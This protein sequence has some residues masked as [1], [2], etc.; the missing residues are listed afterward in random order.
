MHLHEMKRREIVALL[1][2]AAVWP[3]AAHAQQPAMPVIGYLGAGWPEASTNLV[4]SFRKGLSEV[5]Y[6]EGRNVAIEFRWAH[7]D[8]ERLSDFAADLVRRGVQVIVTQITTLAA[9]AAKAATTSIPV[10]FGIG[11]DPVRAGLVASFNRP[12]GN[13]T[14][15]HDEYRAFAKAAWALT[16]IIAKRHAVCRAGEPRQSVWC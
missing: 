9:S 6:V 14:C 13:V 10:V 11:S 12:G 15:H 8:N 4:A 1:G 7:N 5:G 16:G 3:F 2:S